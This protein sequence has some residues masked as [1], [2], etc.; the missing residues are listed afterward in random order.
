MVEDLSYLRRR[1]VQLTMMPAREHRSHRSDFR[2]ATVAP[3]S[4]Q[5]SKTAINPV[6]DF[7]TQHLASSLASLLYVPIF[8]TY[9][10]VGH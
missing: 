7:R 5:P 10:R 3:L 8:F 6:F 2:I 1:K 4:G 9:R